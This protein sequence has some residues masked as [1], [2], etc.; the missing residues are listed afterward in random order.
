MKKVEDLNMA[1]EVM[2][3]IITVLL[4]LA[5]AGLFLMYTYGDITGAREFLES[6]N[7]DRGVYAD[8][9]GRLGVFLARGLAVTVLLLLFVASIFFMILAVFGIIA[10]VVN[11]SFHVNRKNIIDPALKVN[12]LEKQ[13]VFNFVYTTVWTVLL[14][15]LTL[16]YLPIGI[17][18]VVFAVAEIISIIAMVKMSELKKTFYRQ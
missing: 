7:Y 11:I 17:V 14:L 2:Y 5:G 16:L 6:T 13:T 3:I 8:G 10:C 15:V 1:I 18:F 4:V 9:V 12:K